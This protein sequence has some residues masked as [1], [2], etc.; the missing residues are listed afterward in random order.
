[1]SAFRKLREPA[2][3]ALAEALRTYYWYKPEFQTLVRAHFAEA[4]EALAAVNFDGTKRTATG[5]LV[6][7]LRLNEQKYQQVVID[8]LV[9][10]SDVDPKFPHL[11]RLDDGAAH[12]TEAKAAYDSVRDV[13]TQY[14]ELVASRES[15]RREAEATIAKESA[16]RLHETKLI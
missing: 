8:A 4:P 6:R 12:V 2:W 10:L 11:G 16:R 15:V 7:A 14:S 9:A 1:M 13:I 3:Q 5:E